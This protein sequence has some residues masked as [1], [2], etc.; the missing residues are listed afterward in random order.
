M[1]ARCSRIGK[2]KHTMQTITPANFSRLFDEFVEL[3]ELV[4]TTEARYEPS[5]VISCLYAAAPEPG[6]ITIKI[7]I[8]EA[9]DV[10]TAFMRDNPA[11]A[12]NIAAHIATFMRKH[13]YEHMFLGHPDHK[14]YQYENPHNENCVV[15]V[16]LQK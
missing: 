16:F 14:Y 10:T 13:G 15:L 4:N 7:N 6:I 9:D 2:R 8:T 11:Y 12:F 5:D 3:A 1:R